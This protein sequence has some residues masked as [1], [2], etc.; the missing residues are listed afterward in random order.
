[1]VIKL[2]ILKVTK[3]SNI[4]TGLLKDYKFDILLFLKCPRQLRYWGR[5]NKKLVKQTNARMTVSPGGLP[6]QNSRGAR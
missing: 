6:T 4:N 3:K 5:G 1:M 2:L